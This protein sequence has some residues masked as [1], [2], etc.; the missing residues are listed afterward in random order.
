MNLLRIVQD[1]THKKENIELSPKM[2]DDAI[3]DLLNSYD[4]K[5]LPYVKD[6]DK[7]L[8]DDDRSLKFLL[9]V[10]IH[11]YLCPKKC[12]FDYGLSK[13]EFDKLM[14]EVC[15]NFMRAIIQPGEMVGVIAAQS[16]GEPTS[17]LSVSKDSTIKIIKCFNG[18]LELI[19]NEIG[20]FCDEIIKN[21]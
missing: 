18:S 7:Y 3:E 19:S 21:T 13:V 5:L 14:L 15:N 1:Y 2:I 20:I 17:Q 6:T 4:T 12:I 9:E 10:A 16:I 11:D 8:L